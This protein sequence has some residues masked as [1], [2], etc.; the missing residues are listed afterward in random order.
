MFYITKGE[1]K[2]KVGDEILLLKGGDSIFI[3]RNVPHAFTITSET[4][5]TF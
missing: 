4:P 1:V 3:P 5:A 2:F